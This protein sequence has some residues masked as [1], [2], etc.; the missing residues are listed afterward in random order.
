MKKWFF[1]LIQWGSVVVI[2]SLAVVYC[3]IESG[4][5][6]SSASS[7][8]P[9]WIRVGIA[10]VALVFL[11]FAFIT[12]A[13]MYKRRRR[14]VVVHNV[15]SVPV[16]KIDLSN[17]ETCYFWANTT[18]TVDSDT[19]CSICL[20][21]EGPGGQSACCHS[22]LHKECAKAYWSSINQ[23]VCPNCRSK[24]GVHQHAVSTV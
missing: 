7:G 24:Q 10:S 4:S 21:E 9:D 18:I 19:F 13:K 1:E 6:S 2:V 5:A 15:V 17:S 8:R 3:V 12:F 16:D 11:C 20:S 14:V 22:F 23:I